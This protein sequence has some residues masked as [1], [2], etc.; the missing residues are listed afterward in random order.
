MQH[1]T[2][3][4]HVTILTHLIGTSMWSA[5]NKNM[6]NT[7]VSCHLQQWFIFNKA[8]RLYVQFSIRFVVY[9]SSLAR[10]EELQA[11]QMLEA[12]RCGGWWCVRT[13]CW[14][15]YGGFSILEAYMHSICKTYPN[16]IMDYVTTKILI[17]GLVTSQ[18]FV[19]IWLPDQ[20]WMCR[21]ATE[22]D[23]GRSLIPFIQVIMNLVSQAQATYR[24]GARSCSCI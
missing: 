15:Y 2:V 10:E 5:H 23:W 14:S 17:L 13:C 11:Q 1:R 19:L 7:L 21:L 8:H 22:F 9:V 18:H 24:F 20:F 4:V 12:A 16:S 3:F 6:Q